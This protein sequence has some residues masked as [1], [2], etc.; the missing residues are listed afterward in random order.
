MTAG[1]GAAVSGAVVSGAARV[2]P[3]DVL[4][5]AGACARAALADAALSVA[6]VGGLLVCGPDASSVSDVLGLRLG[7]RMQVPDRE[8]VGAALVQAVDAVASGRVPV[9]LCVEVDGGEMDAPDRSPAPRRFGQPEVA[10]GWSG[11]HVPYGAGD[12]IV[13][14]AL[15]ARAYIERFGLTRVELSRVALTA[16]TNAGRELHL[17]EYLAAPM[18]AD[19]LCVHDRARPVGGAAAVVVES[20]AVRRRGVRS[21]AVGQVGAAYATSPLPEQEPDR[22]VDSAAAAVRSGWG[23]G[24]V[25]LLGDEYSFDVLWWLEA[26]GCCGSGEAGRFVATGTAIARDGPVP[27]NPHGGHLGLGRRPDLDL[28]VEAAR[29]LRGE[30]GRGQVP[31]PPRAAVL[32]LGG[33]GAA[34]CLLLHR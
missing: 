5:T 19:P 32:G 27:V 11:W 1:A 12:P 20:Q 21:V 16:A 2:A 23:A 24:T 26:L 33:R 25:M 3:G 34:G 29:Q 17:R 8:E 13:A 4:A 15:D 31:G 7:W 30:A 18:V 9:V 10:S 28:A 22:V 6:E 14:V